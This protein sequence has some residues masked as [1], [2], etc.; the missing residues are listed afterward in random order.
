MKKYFK[1]LACLFA[2]AIVLTSCDD[3]DDFVIEYQDV[4]VAD[5]V[6][7]LNEGSYFSQVNGSLDYLDYAAGSV[8]RNV[9]QSANGRALGGTPNNAILCGSKLYIATQE[10]NR[11]EVV[12]A[13][14]LKA[15]TPVSVTSP[16]ELCTDGESVYVSSYTGEV[17]KIDTLSLKV[18][19][20]SDVV[21]TNLE[22]IA[23]RNGSVYVCNAWNSDYTYNTNLV[24]LDAQ[25]LK[26]QKDVIVAA[27][28]NQLIASGD[29]LYVAS[30]GN[31]GDVQA[32]IQQVNERDEVSI[33]THATH[34]ALGNGCLY[35]IGSSYDSN[36]NEV[37]SY[38][39]FNLSTGK[40][41][42]FTEGSDIISPVAIGVDPLSGE[43]F[44]SSR[45][46]DPDTGGASYTTDGYIVR[47]SNNGSVLARYNC[48]VSPGTLV[49][50]SHNEKKIVVK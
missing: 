21:G 25:T 32:T 35:L 18:T 27:N 23:Y 41:T 47:Y 3:D 15:L 48:G 5:G 49:F 22:G 30:W 29:E 4:A 17:S 24:K 40:E 43:V 9:F 50:V 33:L 36:W 38:T 11:V 20:K 6:F 37:N 7:I 10:E 16:R 28:P 46:K 44:I 34:M 8:S 19:L 45:S 42:T 39:V 31:Y 13:K 14:T 26:K 1:L 12:D 2:G